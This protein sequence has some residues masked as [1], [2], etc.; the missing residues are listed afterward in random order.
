MVLSLGR[1]YSI[2][3]LCQS[4]GRANG[5]GKKVLEENGFTCV[6]IL[7]TADDLIICNKMRNYLREVGKRMQAEETFAEAVSFESTFLMCLS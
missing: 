5:N 2:S 7:A 6:T 1:G 3:S 4:A